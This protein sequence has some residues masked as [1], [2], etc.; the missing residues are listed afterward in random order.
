MQKCRKTKLKAK[1]LKV[2]DNFKL[3]GTVYRIENIQKNNFNESVI[4][5]YPIDGNVR[6]TNVLIIGRYT[7]LNVLNQK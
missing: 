5:F 1:D 6:Q 4:H 3:G 7:L 2:D